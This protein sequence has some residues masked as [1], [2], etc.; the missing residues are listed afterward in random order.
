MN[1]PAPWTV[2]GKWGK[3][4]NWGRWGRERQARN[5]ERHQ[6]GDDRE[7]RR[8]GEAGKG[9]R[10]GRG[11]PRRRRAGGAAGALRGPG[12]PGARRVRSRRGDVRELRPKRYQGA[13]SFTIM[14]NH[15]GSHLDTFGTSTGRT[16]SSTTCHRRRLPA[17]SMATRRVSNSWSGVVSC[18][19][20]PSTKGVTRFPS[21]TGSPSRISR[22]PRRRR[23]WR[24]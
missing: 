18:S 24:S 4:G 1:E 17:P 11:A 20:S 8:P 14:H 23:R 2:P 21:I 10:S 9:L 7:R 15:T 5:A 3:R 16:P 12:R 13:A 22:T 6:R 19:T